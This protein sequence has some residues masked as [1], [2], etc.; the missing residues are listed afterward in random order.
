[1]YLQLYSLI[2]EHIFAGAEIT[3]HVELVCTLIAT[4]GCLALV[5]L[6]FVMVYWFFN[7]FF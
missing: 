1:M 5:A 4:L 7:K 6:P 3:A 2:M